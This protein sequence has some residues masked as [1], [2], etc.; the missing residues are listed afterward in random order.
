MT[1]PVRRNERKKTPRRGITRPVSSTSPSNAASSTDGKHSESG[2]I[3][4]RRGA[5]SCTLKTL[6]RM[7]NL[8]STIYFLLDALGHNQ[9]R[10]FIPRVTDKSGPFLA[11]GD[12]YGSPCRARASRG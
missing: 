12:I 3:V 11:S 7:R 2:R 8:S 1:G 6:L 5:A 4:D 9:L 10:L